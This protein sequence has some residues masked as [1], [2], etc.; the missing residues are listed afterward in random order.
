MTS[1]SNDIIRKQIIDLCM[2]GRETGAGFTK[3]LKCKICLK[4]K[5]KVLNVNTFV[6]KLR[7]NL[8]LDKMEFTKGLRQNFV[9]RFVLTLRP[10]KGRLMSFF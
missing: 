4:Y 6:I 5:I 2:G 1:L 8:C 3:G 10:V 7:Q 9:L